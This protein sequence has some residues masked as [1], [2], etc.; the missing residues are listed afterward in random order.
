MTMH[1]GRASASKWV[2]WVATVATALGVSLLA[3]CGGGNAD[4]DASSNPP[5]QSATYAATIR[6]TSYGVPHVLA[7][8]YKGAGYGYGYAFAKDNICL[9]A[10]ELV[11]MHG[12]RS[13]YFGVRDAQ[14]NPITYL[15]QLGG[16]VDN[17]SSDFFYK[18]LMTPAQAAAIK[19]SSSQN[20]QD[21]VSGFV[22]GYNRYLRETG[23]SGLP[24]ECKNAPWVQPMTETDAYYRFTQASIAGSSLAFITQ[25][26][27]A[28]P[29]SGTSAASLKQVSA[30]PAQWVAGSSLLNA[31][32]V[33][34]AHMIGSNGLGLGHDVTQ[35][36]VGI[37]LGNPHF[38]W[39]GALRLHQ[40]HLT[41]PGSYDVYG[42]TLLGVPLPLI[43]FNKDVAWTHTFST[44]NRFTLAALQI[45]PAN[46]THYMVDGK[47]VAMTPVPLTITATQPDGS[48][49][50]IS[51]TLYTTQYG[52]MVQDSTFAWTAASAFALQDANYG[53][54][55]MIDQVLLN[56]QA[57][58]A[59][60]L[61]T[62][63]ATYSAMPWVNT[64]S[65]DRTGQAM[66]A[67]YSVAANVPDAQLAQCVKGPMAQY[68]LATNGTVILDGST[69]SCAW[70]G[71]LPSSQRPWVTRTDY[72][73]NSNDSH[74]LPNANVRLAGYPMIIATGPTAEATP[75]G[76]RT[77]VG[78][79]QVMD[80]V[81]GAD[82]LPGTGF[83]VANLQQVY[84]MLRF[85]KPE[86]WLN[87]FVT[88][89]LASPVVT[90]AKGPV[91]LTQACTVLKQWDKHHGPTSAGA[92]LF[93]EFYG[94][95]NE[96][97]DQYGQP[98]Y[99]RVPFDPANPITTPAGYNTA[100]PVPM[101]ALAGVVAQF[102]ALGV[103]LAEIPAKR[104]IIYRNGAPL[105]I[106]GGRYTYFNWQGNP[107][108]TGYYSDP[109][110]G[111]SYIQFVTWD[112]N[113]PVAQ[114][115]LTYSQSSHT[116]SSNYADLTTL[117]AQGGWANLP[118]T[119]A[120]ITSDPGYSVTQISE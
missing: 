110:Y 107:T 41:I 98:S 119:D 2:D 77:R 109:A 91:D 112:A 25:I 54:Y 40:L 95:M 79:A 5:A 1:M 24:L 108:G 89:C 65:A 99:W 42:A 88:A 115:M 4:S 118:F 75:Q 55:K 51:R 61:R 17:V 76:E 80:R 21:I 30:S 45:D 87:E 114:G 60:S 69:S 27:N 50:Q 116:L 11:T 37:V 35:S 38:P 68:I 72:V 52:P 104:Q 97:N 102:N 84:G 70:S 23:V 78:I 62:A 57:T 12:E 48:T 103:P 26:A 29:P 85:Y 83:T 22:A 93:Q 7:T 94:A 64:I 73:M 39:W 113:G 96:L 106:R 74:W 32:K 66:Y 33:F 90:T 111:N 117:Y 120:Q 28:Q 71:I 46:K 20:A 3:S 14:G 86:V 53:N 47:S 49:T 82:G 100:N 92:L 19:A 101:Q 105:S 18:L 56:G 13:R 9:F 10:N 15:G 8:N 81:S 59:A 63:L 36:G 43:G 31:E 44:D 34:K 6:Y 67:N 58:S 16:F